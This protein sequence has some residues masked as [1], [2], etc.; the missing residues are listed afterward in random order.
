MAEMRRYD[1]SGYAG[2]LAFGGSLAELYR[3]HGWHDRVWVWHEAADVAL[4]RPLRRAKR[5]DLV[6][7]GNW[8]DGERTAELRRH[9]AQ[10]VSVAVVPIGDQRVVEKDDLHARNAEALVVASA[11]LSGSSDVAAR[12]VLR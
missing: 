8:G 6:W 7:I 1:L 3:D 10:E 11:V 5:G 12:K 2:V 9:A 4:F